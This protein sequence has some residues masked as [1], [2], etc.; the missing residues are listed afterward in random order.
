MSKM[1]DIQK[2]PG[3]NHD[4]PDASTGPFEKIFGPVRSRPD[5]RVTSTRVLAP[6]GD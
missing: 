2:A 6:N 5:V 1:S 4:R 3:A